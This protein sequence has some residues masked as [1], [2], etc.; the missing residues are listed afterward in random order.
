LLLVVEEQADSK[1]MDVREAFRR[2]HAAYVDAISNPF[3]V[4]GHA[5]M[6]PGFEAN[7]RGIITET[8]RR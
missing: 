6:S 8:N 5:L 4:Q 3:H 7:V 1:T 2:L